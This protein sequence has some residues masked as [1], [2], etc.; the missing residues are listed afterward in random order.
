MNITVKNIFNLF[1]SERFPKAMLLDGYVYAMNEYILVRVPVQTGETIALGTFGEAEKRIVRAVSHA[2]DFSTD[3]N[4]RSITLREPRSY[5][6]EECSCVETFGKFCGDCIVGWRLSPVGVK[7]ENGV[8]LSQEV[9][10]KLKKLPGLQCYLTVPTHDPYRARHGYYL[11]SSGDG[12]FV[13]MR[14]SAETIEE[15]K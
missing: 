3:N 13:P 14:P 8:I 11:F 15:W 4:R 10:F 7:Q 2:F 6:W 5:I 1:C 9:I 12:V